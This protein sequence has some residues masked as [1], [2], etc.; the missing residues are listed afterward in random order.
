MRTTLF[1]VLLASAITSPVWQED[2]ECP[3]GGVQLLQSAK[4]GIYKQMPKPG[5]MPNE[6]IPF[7]SLV[8]ESSSS[9][10]PVMLNQIKQ[11]VELAQTRVQTKVGEAP[12]FIIAVAIG[13]FALSLISICISLIFVERGPSK[14]GVAEEP[15]ATALL[16]GRLRAMGFWVAVKELKLSY[17]I[18]EALL[19][20]IS[21][22]YGNLM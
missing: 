20:A 8:S 21:T 1:P 14:D 9:S 22:R 13:G 16:A 10:Q 3:D 18:G 5:D 6:A 17:Y 2:S 15:N 7:S 11:V 12:Y 19:F 4:R